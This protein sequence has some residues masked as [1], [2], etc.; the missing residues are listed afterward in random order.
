MSADYSQIELRVLSHVA[1]I[2]QLQNAFLDDLDIHQMTASKIF[3]TPLNEVTEKMR[4]SAKAINFG[5]I[6]GISAFGLSKQ[7]KIQRKDVSN[8]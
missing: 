2:Q 7:L 6:Y 8:L 5:I 1:N 3:S 4:Y